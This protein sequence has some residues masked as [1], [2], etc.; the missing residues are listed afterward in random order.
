MRKKK[1]YEKPTMEVVPFNQQCQLL[2]DSLESTRVPYG[3]PIF[4]DWE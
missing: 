1:D 2:A 4:E 3:D